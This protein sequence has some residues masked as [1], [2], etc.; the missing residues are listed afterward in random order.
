MPFKKNQI[1]TLQIE[2]LSNDGSGVAHQDGQA[3]FV[4]LTAPG[5]VTEVRIVKPMKTYAFWSRGKTHHRRAE[6]H[7]AGLPGGRALRRL[8]VAAYQ[9]PGRVR[10]QDAVCARRLCPPG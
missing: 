5:D 4:P 9:L 6:P 7:S 8:W 10:R 1:V 2:S 3:V